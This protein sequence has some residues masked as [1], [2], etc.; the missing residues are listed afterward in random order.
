NV[1]IGRQGELL[2]SDFGIAVLTQT[3]RTSLSSAYD[4]GGTPY[5]MAP[6]TYRG[7]PVKES[8]QYALAVMVYEWLCGSVPFTEGNFIQLGYQHATEPVP[9]LREINP[10]VPPYVEEVVRI[11][12]SKEPKDRFAS[13][14]AFVQ[15][16][17]QASI[18]TLPAE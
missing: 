4:I 1:L 17:E 10:A 5:Y 8:D 9:P 12:L 2:V 13:V 16:F 11:A 7:K 14:Q 6:E 3:G 15:A 18:P